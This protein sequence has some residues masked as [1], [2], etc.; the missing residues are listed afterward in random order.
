MICSF[1]LP[2][3]RRSDCPEFW[4]SEEL[5]ASLA[6]GDLLRLDLPAWAE[7]LAAW[8]DERSTRGSAL[9][10]LACEWLEMR[11][12]WRA[13]CARLLPLLL[14]QDLLRFADGLLAEGGYV[15]SSGGDGLAA[16]A[17]AGAAWGGGGGPASA[18]PAA[19]LVLRDVRWASLDELALA[20]AAG[21]SQGPLLRLL[22]EEEGAEVPTRVLRLLR[23]MHEVP[24]AVHWQLRRQRLEQLRAADREAEWRGRGAEAG[25]QLVPV[26]AEL[27]CLLLLQLLAAG[28][29][30]QEAAKSTE[31]GSALH[32]QTL[33]AGSGVECEVAAGC[34]Y[35]PL[36]EA[37]SGEWKKRRRRKSS[38][39]RK[40][41]REERRRLEGGRR[42]SEGDSGSSDGLDGDGAD[43]KAAA[44]ADAR[45][46]LRWPDGTA[47]S[48]VLSTF[49]L[50][51]A[52]MHHTAA[53]YA[54]WRFGRA[55][56]RV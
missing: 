4:E 55:A 9:Y 47:S 23:A 33:L 11:A 16:S 18:L 30:L 12:S 5:R 3:M 42:G 14:P 35:S 10:A 39:K 24:T 31:P 48:T 15:S 43:I 51:D 27:H 19:W 46:R 54:D 13:L 29:A 34:A 50:C 20:S 52:V 56:E 37:G 26:A 7:E 2:K 1:L 22:R 49:E 41:W 40:W 8:L 6:G 25:E 17:G 45:W 53:A 38:N 44:A 21:C 28:L 36:A 32:L